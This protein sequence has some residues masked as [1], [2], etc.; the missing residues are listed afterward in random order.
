MVL[1]KIFRNVIWLGCGE[2]AVKGGLR[3]ATMLVA[4]GWG[5]S[6][7]GTFAIGF[8]AALIAVMVLAFGQQEVLIREVARS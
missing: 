8:S 3:A 6:G 5:P 7:L 4:R 1:T 2:A